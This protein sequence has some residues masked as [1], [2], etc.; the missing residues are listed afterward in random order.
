[1]TFREP[2]Q[3]YRLC[4]QYLKKNIERLEEDL[5]T[6]QAKVTISCIILG[7]S[8]IVNEYNLWGSA[9]ECLQA[10]PRIKQNIFSEKELGNEEKN[11]SSYYYLRAFIHKDKEKIDEILFY[12]GLKIPENEKEEFIEQFY[13]FAQ[14]SI[15][16]CLDIFRKEIP[17]IKEEE[18]LDERLNLA[19][20]NKLSLEKQSE[21]FVEKVCGKRKNLHDGAEDIAVLKKQNT[22][23]RWGENKSYPECG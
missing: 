23:I 14:K 8:R 13:D 10:I 21:S 5:S 6:E 9:L 7:I 12:K 17:N 1:M 16:I 19:K 11:K 4:K 20:R 22:S 18:A 3:Y 2:P 15:E